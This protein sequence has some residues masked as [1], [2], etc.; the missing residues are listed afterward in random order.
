VSP[1]PIRAV[2]LGTPAAAVP[3]LISLAALAEV[4]A[5][6]TRPDKPRGR[7]ARP[8]P[9]PVK[10]AA[11][12]LGLTT[13]QPAD[14]SQLTETLKGIGHIDVGVVTAYGTLIRPEALALPARGFLNVH[15]SLLPRWRGANPV[16]AALLAGD[17]DTGV[18]LMLLDQGLDTGPVVAESTVVIGRDETGGEL[19]TRL[20]T[21]GARMLIEFL[22]W[23]VAGAS[24]ATPQPA[25]G[26]TH[27]PKLAKSELLLNTS[28]SAEA[29]ARRIRA[30]APSPGAVL[31]AGGMNVRVLAGRTIR[32]NLEVG[33]LAALDERVLVG[34]GRESLELLVVQP[35]GKRPMAA[36]AWLRGLRT[37]PTNVGS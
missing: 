35:P 15:F 29:L 4:V 28:E 33:E 10:E 17:P 2:F 20:A 5:V 1:P 12:G 34:T 16:V 6:V 21:L 24:P 32:R 3:S 37:P 23:W 9:S 7:S 27:A 19:T 8:V 26:V 14:A 18:S 13:L 25:I 36:A 31:M 30:L 22:P 11:A